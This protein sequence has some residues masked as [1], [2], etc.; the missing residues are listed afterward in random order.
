MTLPLAGGTLDR[1]GERRADDGWVASLR[2]TGEGVDLATGDARPLRDDDEPLALLGLREDGTP[3]WLLPG[4]PSRDLRGRLT[5]EADPATQG[6]LAYAAHLS[7]FHHTHRF[8]GRCGVPTEAAEAG[9]ARRCAA[10]HVAHPRTDP[11]AIM[12]VEDGPDR[13]LLGRQPS[14]PAGRFSALAGF[15]EP[16]EALESAVAREVREEAGVATGPVRYVASQPWP[17]PAS[18]MLGFRAVYAGGEA[19]VGDEELE[20]VRWFDRDEVADAA[21]HDEGWT[22]DGGEGLI[23]PPR[24]AIARHLVEHWLAGH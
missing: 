14:W 21:R 9:H 12:L 6:L 3:L 13:I 2:G 8:C 24:L 10:G 4:P 18:L 22:A 16:G 23:L 5:L 17:F 15:V 20:E 7:H 11:V 1:A 19:R